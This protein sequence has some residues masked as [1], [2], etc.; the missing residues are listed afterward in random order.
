[1][2]FTKDTPYQPEYEVNVL[3]VDNLTVD[4]G[5]L[6]M[7]RDFYHGVLKLPVQFEFFDAGLIGFRIGQEQPGLIVRAANVR[8]SAP[9]ASP[10]LWLEVVDARAAVTALITAG[11]NPLG[12]PRELQTGWVAE[13]ADPWGNVIGLTDYVKAPHHARRQFDPIATQPMPPAPG[14]AQTEEMGWTVQ[15]H[16]PHTPGPRMLPPPRR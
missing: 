12:P 8:T 15:V 9:K 7:A 10:Q 2:E 14:D 13:A 1:M 11:V 4:V 16:R 5:D 3:G 6:E